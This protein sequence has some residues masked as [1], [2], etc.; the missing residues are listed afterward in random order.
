MHECLALDKKEAE[1]L[2]EAIFTVNELYDGGFISPKAA[3]WGNLIM[4][5]GTIYGPR[6]MVMLFKKKLAAQQKELTQ[7]E[8]N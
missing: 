7:N 8:N 6:A 1:Q 2:S 4:C 3:A 5:A